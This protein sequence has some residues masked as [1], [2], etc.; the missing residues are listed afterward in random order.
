MQPLVDRAAAA[1]RDR[2]GMPHTEADAGLIAQ[3]RQMTA[4]LEAQQAQIDRAL[5]ELAEAMH[6]EPGTLEKE[7]LALPEITYPRRT[8][9]DYEPST[10]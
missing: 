7:D 9:S 2:F 10:D 8:A 6:T 4:R 1:Y 3:L 5:D